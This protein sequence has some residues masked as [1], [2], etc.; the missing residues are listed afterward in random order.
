MAISDA[1]LKTWIWT[2]VVLLALVVLYTMAFAFWNSDEE[3][4]LWLFVGREPRLNVLV[5]LLGAFALGALVTALLRTVISTVRQ[6]Q[7]SKER[8][9]TLRLEREIADMRTKASTLRTRPEE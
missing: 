9:R 6:F 8:N 5:A 2:K 1:L 4:T 3:I 7:R